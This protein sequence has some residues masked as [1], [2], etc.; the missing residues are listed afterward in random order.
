M[1][2]RY[3]RQIDLCFKPTTKVRTELS[4]PYGILFS[5]NEKLIRYTSKFERVI[6]VGD[7]VTNLVSLHMTPF[8]S[9]IDG[10]TKRNK[11]LDHRETEFRVINEPG[12]LRLSVMSKIKSIMENSKPTSL[13]VDGEDDMM[14]IP[15][16]MYGK[17]GDLIIYGQPNA[18]AVCL[19]NW[20]GSRWR[21][22]DILSK[23]TVEPC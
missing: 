20:S 3:K 2:I 4:R 7:V 14:V 10:K 21:V 9:I 16:I 8:L 18:G 22:R 17:D 5:D 1:E 19:E 12:I 23:F 6:T 11:T 13:F 15:V